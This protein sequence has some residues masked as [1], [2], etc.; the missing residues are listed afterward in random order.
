MNLGCAHPEAVVSVATVLWG[1]A[2]PSLMGR[3]PAGVKASAVRLR[4]PPRAGVRSQG[5]GAATFRAAKIR[6]APAWR[7]ARKHTP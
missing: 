3:A 1:A 2:P 6:P 4:I 5:R 7:P